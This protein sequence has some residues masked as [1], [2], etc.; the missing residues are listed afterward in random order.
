MLAFLSKGVRVPEEHAY[1]G[2]AAQ[3][4]GPDG[5][6]FDWTAVTRGLFQVCSQ[7]KRPK[8]AAVA[9][10]YEGYWYFIAASDKRSKSTLALMEMSA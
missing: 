5:I 8:D 2:L 4:V 9:I 1:R 3:T 7:K 10:E 6:T